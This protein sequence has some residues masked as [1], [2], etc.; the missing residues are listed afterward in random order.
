[1]Q[2]GKH[3]GDVEFGRLAVRVVR[4]RRRGRVGRP[5]GALGLALVLALDLPP[6]VLTVR[7]PRIR[8]HRALLLA[9]VERDADE[10]ALG[11][12]E[13]REL[14]RDGVGSGGVLGRRCERV[15]RR[16]CGVRDEA[17]AEEEG[18]AQ[19]EER[20]EVQAGDFFPDCEAGLAGQ[21]S[22]RGRCC[23]HELNQGEEE[24]RSARSKPFICQCEHT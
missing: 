4:D 3:D 1:M 24:S 7:R 18:R 16:E 12:P 10:P 20:V 22:L 6:D 19:G 9:V 11:V 13:A 5:L 14:R 21:R 2:H 17:C 23:G 8:T 15:G